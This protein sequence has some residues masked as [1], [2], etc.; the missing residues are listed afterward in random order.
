MATDA[1]KPNDGPVGEKP[2]K[3]SAERD[4][5]QPLAEHPGGPAEE[6]A[7]AK[8]AAPPS[9]HPS[10]SKP[11]TKPKPAAPKAEHGISAPRRPDRRLLRAG[12]LT[13]ALLVGLATWL[14]T[15]DDDSREEPGGIGRIA[16]LEELR[17]VRDTLGQ[18]IYWAGPIPFSR[19][20]LRELDH[21]VQLIYLPLDGPTGEEPPKT[22][23][24]GSYP[25]P[26][27][28]KAVEGF[29]RRPGSVVRRAADGRELVFSRGTPTSVYF[30]SPDNTVQVEVYAPSPRQALDV[31]GGVQPID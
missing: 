11:A 26:D 25:L 15:R 22:L 23:T 7:D 1:D 24:V 10:K 18:P 2:G 14:V 29:A 28:A 3:K 4:H 13:L 31:A 6:G 9:K 16:T 20:E 5:E 12:V 27:P 8:A 21:G 17:E 30:A 19:V